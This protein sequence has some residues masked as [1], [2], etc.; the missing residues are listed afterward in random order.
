MLQLLQALITDPA[1]DRLAVVLLF[2]R[3][4][5]GEPNVTLEQVEAGLT[6]DDLFEALESIGTVEEVDDDGEVVGSGN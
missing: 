2:C 4:Q 6:Y 1:L 5:N 3:R